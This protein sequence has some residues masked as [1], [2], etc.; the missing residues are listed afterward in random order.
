MKNVKEKG[1]TYCIFKRDICY[2]Y[3]FSPEYFEKMVGNIKILKRI[4]NKYDTNHD[5]EK[6]S[7][8]IEVYK[9]GMLSEVYKL[10]ESNFIKIFG[11]ELT[12]KIDAK[13]PL[14]DECTQY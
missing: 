4:L 3:L 8:S 2:D 10:D 1:I 7:Y 13:E 9:D 5:I 12:D 6:C 11:K 14:E